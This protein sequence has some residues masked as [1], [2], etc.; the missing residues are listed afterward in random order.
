MFLEMSV[1][2][3]TLTSDIT[4]TLPELA[5]K[6]EKLA[7]LRKKPKLNI[8]IHQEEAQKLKLLFQD[9]IWIHWNL[10]R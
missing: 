8:K 1:L 3:R 5:E 7:K 2:L 9:F 10:K 6:I 4:Q